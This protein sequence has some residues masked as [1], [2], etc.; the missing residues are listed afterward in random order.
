M[1]NVQGSGVQGGLRLAYVANF[2]S[3]LLTIVIVLEDRNLFVGFSHPIHH[4][5]LVG[6]LHHMRAS[7]AEYSLPRTLLV[8]FVSDVSIL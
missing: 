6:E 4:V 3:K 2:K 7:M 8:L 5:F 1:H